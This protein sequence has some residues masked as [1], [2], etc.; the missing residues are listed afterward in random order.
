[1]FFV[2]FMK[3]KNY[4]WTT[5][6][7][8][9]YT[10]PQPP[11]GFQHVCA[12]GS[13]SV[14]VRKGTIRPMVIRLY[15]DSMLYVYAYNP[16][17]RRA[18]IAWSSAVF[19]GKEKTHTT[20]KKKTSRWHNDP[21]K[22]QLRARTRTSSPS[23]PR[24]S[25][26]VLGKTLFH[27]DT[28]RHIIIY[29]YRRVFVSPKGSLNLYIKGCQRVRWLYRSAVWNYYR[30]VFREK[31]AFAA[32]LRSAERGPGV[33]VRIILWRA[34]TDIHRVFEGPQHHRFWFKTFNRC[35]VAQISSHG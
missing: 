27:R 35:F 15:L 34:R 17:C 12:L 19:R 6:T 25:T 9:L 20:T 32:T 23:S 1:M 31:H 10:W 30:T 14:M 24:A 28:P 8:V 22:E 3:P 7:F 13:P 2:V 5:T 11:P 21:D 4:I 18:Y 26:Y 33:G 16:I 29:V